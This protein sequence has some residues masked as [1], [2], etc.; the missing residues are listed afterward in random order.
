MCHTGLYMNFEK[1]IINSIDNRHPGEHPVILEMHPR[2]QEL[3]NNDEIKPKNFIDLYGQEGVGAD[4]KE[5]KELKERFE[6]RRTPEEKKSKRVSEVLEAIIYLHTE[7]SNWLG[8]NAETIRTSEYD[9]IKN[10]VDLIAE[11][12]T[13]D[14]TRHLAL[15]VD[16]TFSTFYLETKINRIKNEIEADELAQVKYF[17]SHG[18][19]GSLRQL[20]RVVIG[21]EADKVIELAGLWMRNKNAELGRHPAKNI[22]LVEIVE[23]LKIFRDYAEKLGKTNALKSYDQTIRTLQPLLDT[24]KKM[25][26]KDRELVSEDRVYDSIKFQISHRFNEKPKSQTSS[27][28]TAKRVQL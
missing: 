15:G 8:P 5:T 22:I 12:N 16:V 9:D 25:S 24:V 13:E 27:S 20:P 14:S 11:F 3:F 1:E 10:G 18:F 19:K 21:V 26:Q 4:L 6:E 7:L 17:E 28:S 23:Q 2:A